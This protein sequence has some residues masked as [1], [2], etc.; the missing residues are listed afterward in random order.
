MASD[1]VSLIIP[2]D[3]SSSSSSS[4]FLCGPASGPEDDEGFSQPAPVKSRD[5]VL[6]E[7][8]IVVV[9]LCPG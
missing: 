5:E 2:S 4:S 1:P 9:L 6:I 7:V 8:R 3:S